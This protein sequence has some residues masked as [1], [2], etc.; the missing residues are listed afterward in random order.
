MS[1]EQ[2]IQKNN[3]ERYAMRV[4]FIAILFF[5]Y[6]IGTGIYD[7]IKYSMPDFLM[8]GAQYEKFASND[9]Y[10]QQVFGACFVSGNSGVRLPDEA[11]TAK[12]E[13]ALKS[14]T[15]GSKHNAL[16]SLFWSIIFAPI[17]FVVWLMHWR[18]GTKARE[19]QGVTD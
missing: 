17:T 18:I 14:E 9:G 1:S 10:C 5:A 12:R 7:F 16:V 6:F 8:S 4:C 2:K 13:A 19:S 3:L 11:I 15:V